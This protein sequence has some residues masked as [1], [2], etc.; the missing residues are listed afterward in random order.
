MR[1][2]RITLQI[3]YILFL[4]LWAY[5]AFSKI[6]E[7]EI[8][9]YQLGKSPLLAP[10]NGI[11]AIMIPFIE[12]VIVAMLLFDKTKKRGLQA[13][14]LLLTIFTVYLIGILSF[15]KDIPCSCGGLLSTLTW[16]QHVFLN[17][18]FIVMAVFGLIFEK[19]DPQKNFTGKTG[20]A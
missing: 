1:A 19:K 11:M 2:K 4:A 5:A 12:L 16:T 13:S 14:A 20:I 6:F 8:F 9:K 10:V 17:I 3:I 18:S 7:Y 15:S